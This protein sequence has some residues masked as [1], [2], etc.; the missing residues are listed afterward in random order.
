MLFTCETQWR[1][2]QVVSLPDGKWA[3]LEIRQ[4]GSQAVCVCVVITGATKYSVPAVPFFNLLQNLAI[5]VKAS[6]K[7]MAVWIEVVGKT[8]RT[9]K[10]ET[11][12]AI[13]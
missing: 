11:I 12:K 4:Y 2:V 13:W 9:R 8:T 6:H 3:P 1:T 7:R 10:N 5:F